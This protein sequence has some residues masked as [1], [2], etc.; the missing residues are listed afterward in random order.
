MDCEPLT[1]LL[2]LQ[3]PDAVQAVAFVA[4]QVSVELVPLVTELGAALIETV[5]AGALTE[6]VAD[7]L[8]FVRSPVQVKEYVVL[9]DTAPVDCEPLSALLPLQPPDAVQAMALVLDQVSVEAPPAFTLL[10]VAVSVTVGALWETV[11][12]AD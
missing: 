7:W 2:P 6:T 9:A 11:T 5:G 4:D 12:V 10:G 8:A 1:A 3:P